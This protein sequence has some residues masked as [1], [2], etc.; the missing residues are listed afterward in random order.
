MKKILFISA[1]LL[2]IA[3]CGKLDE[4]AE[5]NHNEVL[6]TVELHF[7]QIS[8]GVETVYKWE[9]LDGDGGNNPVIENISLLANK[10]YEVEIEL[11]DKTKNPIEDITHEI[12]Q[13]SD[14]HRFYYIPNAGN[15]TVVNYDKDVNGVDVGLR[16]QWITSAA[17]NSIMKVVL[18][19][20]A[21]GGKLQSDL[22]SDNKSS[23][24][25]DISFNVRV[26]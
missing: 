20:Y 5:H 23:T 25:M 9:D 18:R 10:E 21:N 19:H 15:I 12:E 8:N 24:D 26:Q 17:G 14:E 16:T 11:L 1:L 7:K 6:T 13:E 2:I 22:V 4:E 3:S